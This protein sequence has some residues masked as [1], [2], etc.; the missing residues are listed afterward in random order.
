MKAM[1]IYDS[2]Y[3]NTEKIAEAIGH[4]GSQDEIE[5]V[6]VRHMKLEQ[7][8]GLK[9]LI[10]GSPTQ[11]GRPTQVMQEF[12]DRVPESIVN[13]IQVATF[14]TRFTTKLVAI[15]GYASEKIAATMEGKGYKLI[16]PPEAFFIKGKKGP[17]KDGE[18]ERATSW[19][20]K[21]MNAYRLHNDTK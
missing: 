5:I 17:L 8:K 13:G 10:L 4:A 2:F 19:G 3:G 7:L 14:D 15:F 6:H 18:L 12:L 16:A 20:N 9:L 11:G 1:I 21:V